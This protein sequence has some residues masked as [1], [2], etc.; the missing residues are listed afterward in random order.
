[1]LSINSHLKV[2]SRI[3]GPSALP[4]TLNAFHIT[5]TRPQDSTPSILFPSNNDPIHITHLTVTN[6]N[7][8][9]Q[10]STSVSTAIPITSIRGNHTE[11]E[12]GYLSEAILSHV[13]SA[14][15]EGGVMFQHHD[16]ARIF[17]ELPP[18]YTD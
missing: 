6:S 5:S 18:P 9:T 15:V 13:D 14:E 12:G 3:T 10:L 1:M 2:T 8:N 7:A 16:G 4:T 11:V 17:D